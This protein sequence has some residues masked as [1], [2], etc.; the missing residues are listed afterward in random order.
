MAYLPSEA[1]VIRPIATPPTCL[2]KGTPASISA[3]EPAQTVAI[4]DDPFDSRISDTMRIVYGLSVSAG[5]VCLSARNARLP[6]PTSR[7]PGPR[8]GFTSP[9]EKPGKL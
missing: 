1:R 6:C 3:S 9:V 8:L 7:R 5:I 4:D 2:G